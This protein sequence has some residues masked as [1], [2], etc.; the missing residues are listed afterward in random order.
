TALP[1]TL[2]SCAVLG[3][4]IMMGA[5]WAYESL[6]FGGYWA[7]DP[8]ENASLVPWLILVAGLHTQL[9][10]NSTKHSLR[11][12]FLFL[13]LGFSFILYSTY[14]TRSGR[15]DDTSVHAFVSSGMEIQLLS[16]IGVFFLPAMVLFA[17]R[18]R[19]IPHMAKEENTW[20]R[21]FWM[22]IGSLVIFLSAIFIIGVTSL[23]VFNHVFGTNH[24]MD[25]DPKFVY[26]RIEIF[27]AILLGLLTAIVQYLRYKD[28]DS[29]RVVAK[30][31]P[32]TA[33]ALIVSVCISLLGNV[34]Y[35]VYGTG[36]QDAI[37]PAI[38]AGVYFVMANLAYLITVLRGNIRRAGA[39]IAHAGFGLLLIGILI[40]SS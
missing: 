28:T 32:V 18:Y 19:R 16:L 31:W 12:T 17:A 23:P 38:F 20:S 30:L 40:S 14:L 34:Q 21:E 1:W 29:Y 5:A 13:I 36:F 3:T 6:T 24:V 4:G 33:I 10:Y 39:S 2:F 8:V 37:P 7:W 15:L 27:I 11:A 26:N 25:D 22:F 9:V 35:E